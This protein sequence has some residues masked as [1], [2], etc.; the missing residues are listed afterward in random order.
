MAKLTSFCPRCQNPAIEKSRTVLPD[1]GF[2]VINLECK[3]SYNIDIEKSANWESIETLDVSKQKLYHYQGLGYEFCRSANFRALIAD[4]PGLGKGQVLSDKILTPTGWKI[5]K[6]VK[7]GEVIIGQDGNPQSITAI[8]DRGILPTYKVLFND[9]SSIT[10]DKEHLWLVNTSTRISR[11]SNWQVKET[12]ELIHTV[13]Q[14]TGKAQWRIPIALPAN[15][16]EQEVKVDPYVLGVLLGDGCLANSARVSFSSIDDEIINEVYKNY[17][18]RKIEG[19][20][21]DYSMTGIIGEI[22][23]L[24]LAGTKSN[25]K[26]VPEAYKFNTYDTRLAILQGLMDTDGSIWNNG[27]IEF[28][29]VSEQLSRDVI[30]LVQSLGGTTR[31]S[32]KIPAYSYKGQKKTGQLCYRVI[33]NIPTNPFRLARKMFDYKPR[34]KYA[35][36]RSIVSIEYAGEQEVRCISVS[37]KD[38]LYVTNDFIVTHN[39]RQS[40]ACLKLHPEK[41]L[42]C[43]IIVKSALKIQYFKECLKILGHEYL[44]QIISDSKEEPMPEL[45][46]IIITTYDLL[47]RVTKKS[48]LLAE[49]KEKEIRSRLNLDEWDIIP[50]DERAKIP[51]VANHF[52][53][54]E[55]KTVILDEC[56]QIKNQE[57]R[58]A[59]QVRDICRNVPHV[60]ATSGSPIENNAGEYFTILNILQPE[61]FPGPWIRFVQNHCD[62]YSSG[63]G[64]KI[65]G[66]RNVKNF[67]SLTNDFIIRR[68]RQE[69][70]PDLPDLNRHFIH[71]DFASDKI[72]R[73]YEEMQEDFSDYYNE[74][75]DD[76]GE[77]F[78]SNILAKMAKLRHKA[79]INKVPFAAEYVEDFLLDTPPSEKIVIFVHHHDVSAGLEGKLKVLFQKMREEGIDIADPLTYTSDLNS[80]QREQ[81]KADF[82]NIEN[83][84]VL[85]ASLLAS[86]EGLDGLQKVSQHCILLERHWN[87]KKE[88]QAEHRLLR[89]GARGKAEGG[90][91][92]ADYILSSGTIDE[93]FTELVEQKRANLDQTLD[94]ADYVWNEQGLM[95]ELAEVLAR[96]GNKKW[97]LQ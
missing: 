39:T 79:G 4:E 30:F 51:E 36:S 41:L 25:N 95:K 66:L 33:I 49:E 68:T 9:G 60:L 12:K 38:N 34:V 83:Q 92:S 52:A 78:Y 3:H 94:N 29:T 89:I 69:V 59:Q 56:Q 71:C 18:I 35:P 17:K 48:A 58:R 11:G 70:L 26:F 19:D 65:G 31:L 16:V 55:F 64:Y 6:D 8:Y 63:R 45:F 5:L 62:Y 22:K 80:N 13:R 47:W 96:K 44:P 61:R 74:H 37:N 10:V 76:G 75:V 50:E 2:I 1:F 91:I 88:E 32:T 86:G 14:S 73:E 40:L 67:R 97:R 72:K 77:E 24:G 28:T 84:R 85:I 7:V 20:N 21:C 54:C 42:P 15:F 46:P 23:K 82:I 81:V 43:L 90:S 87:P 53:K 27:V 57:S 93:Y